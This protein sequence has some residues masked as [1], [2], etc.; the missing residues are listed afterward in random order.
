VCCTDAFK[1]DAAGRCGIAGLQ[2]QREA[3][4]LAGACI[5]LA[6]RCATAGAREPVRPRLRRI[7]AATQCQVQ[8]GGLRR[9]LGLH[10]QPRDARVL[11]HRL[12]LLGIADLDLRAQRPALVQRRKQV[13]A[14][15]VAR[16]AAVLQHQHV[17]G[18]GADA[19]RKADAR[20]LRRL[21][22]ADT[23]EGRGHAVLGRDLVGPALQQ[24]RRQAHRH[25]GGQRRQLPRHGDVGAGAAAEQQLQRAQRLRARQLQLTQQ[26]AAVADVGSGFSHRM[27]VA[28]TDAQPLAGYAPQ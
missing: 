9:R 13:G 3:V 8:V 14:E 12:L 19:G 4:F 7:E 20:Q 18:D 15:A 23:V 2:P 25:C 11:G 5:V 17:A 1:L 21:G 6:E 24:V 22:F 10:A 26:V 27:L 28:D 16:V